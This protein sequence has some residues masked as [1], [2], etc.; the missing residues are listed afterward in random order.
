MWRC[1]GW[2]C[3]DRARYVYDVRA[4]RRHFL[5][6]LSTLLSNDQAGRGISVTVAPHSHEECPY[7]WHAT[8][9]APYAVFDVQ[10]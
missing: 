9:L 2:F 1:R 6:A 8:N 10:G 3:R 5:V 7:E 4:G